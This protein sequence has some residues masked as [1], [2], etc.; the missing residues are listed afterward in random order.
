MRSLEKL[1]KILKI[2]KPECK[3]CFEKIDF[4]DIICLE[5]SH[6]YHPEC[7]NS[8]IKSKIDSKSFPISCP[9]PGWEKN[10]IEDDIRPFWDDDLYNKYL[11]FQFNNYIESNNCFIHCPT[12]DWEYIFEWN[13]DKQNQ[14]F[15]WRIWDKTY[16]MNC[17]VIWHEGM[18]WQQF[19][20][21]KEPSPEDKTFFNFVNGSSLK[22]CPKCRF[23]V[24]KSEGCNH[25]TWRCKFEF[26]YSCGGKYG[27]C[28]WP[29]DIDSDERSDY[30]DSY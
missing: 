15:T 21:E 27:D 13:G 1:K 5:W 17:R 25:M 9:E 12:A 2:I 3:I 18:N 20:E 30:Y 29:S 7:M 26:W 6:I 22:R 16:C 24:E 14:K 8:Y 11:N 10:L 28:E 4:K 23:W 19:E